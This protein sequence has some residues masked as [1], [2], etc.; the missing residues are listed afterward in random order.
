M[1][2][3]AAIIAAAVIT[4]V[5]GPI[6][7]VLLGYA[8]S[9]H[10]KLGAIESTVNGTHSKAVAALA[11]ATAANTV[12]AVENATLRSVPVEPQQEASQ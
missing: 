1:G 9:N 3:T 6:L 8:V 10:R 2:S 5:V 4:G 11:A 7:T 12:L